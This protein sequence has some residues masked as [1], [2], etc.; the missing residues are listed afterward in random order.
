VARL[1][2]GL[3]GTTAMTPAAR[4]TFIRNFADAAERE[5]AALSAPAALSAEAAAAA[6]T[7]V[8]LVGSATTNTATALRTLQVAGAN[9]LLRSLATIARTNPEAVRRILD[10]VG[11]HFEVGS[12]A[13]FRAMVR[14]LE[15][16]G[17]PDALGTVLGY[18]RLH[19]QYTA[20]RALRQLGS[21][22]PAEL[23]GVDELIRFLGGGERA[24]EKVLGIATNYS[25]PGSVF[26]TF[27]EL[28]P[29]S[30]GGLEQ[31]ISYAG[32]VSQ[33]FNQA[34][35]GALW[36]GRAIIA[37]HPGARLRFEVEAQT[38]G[39]LRVADIIV[40]LPP[41]AAS[42]FLRVEIKEI[43][44]FSVLEMGHAVKQFARDVHLELQ[45]PV[46]PGAHRLS[47]L[48][49]MVRRPDRPGGGL[50]TDAELV[51]DRERI[52]IILR[53]AFDEPVIGSPALRRALRA[54]FDAHID[55]IVQFF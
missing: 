22:T 54:E 38:G 23:R 6:E 17:S 52:R 12:Q 14:F 2:A 26:Q 25:E 21:M 20:A 43:A 32:S 30:A 33:N 40:A 49:W 35:L 11:R 5:A 39:F 15:A 42:G 28:I 24:T 37:A 10:G 31:V 1:D 48:R 44:D 46:P 50:K 45:T 9:D 19:G 8:P 3:A 53:S 36:A 13:D 27:A 55:E 7:L 29:V 47:R 18:S 4:R 16:G 34:A 41:G 51:Q